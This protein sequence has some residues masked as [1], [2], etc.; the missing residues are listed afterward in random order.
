M[1][2]AKLLLAAL[3]LA[4]ALPQQALAYTESPYTL[5]FNTPIATVDHAFRVAPNWRH[6]V[7]G[8]DNEYVSYY[9]DSTGGVDGT[10]CLRCSKQELQDSEYDWYAVKDIIVTPMVSGEISFAGK[11]IGSYGY[12]EVYTVNE[13]GRLGTRLQ[14]FDRTELSSSTWNTVS[15]TTPLETSQRIGFRISEAAIDD[16]TAAS[17]ERELEKSLQVVSAVPVAE[18]VDYDGNGATGTIYWYQQPYTVTPEGTEPGKVLVQYTVTVKNDGEVNLAVGDENYSVSI[19][20][21]STNTVYGTT[22]ITQDLAVGATSEPFVVEALVPAT[23]WP[24]SYRY[25]NMNV[26]ENMMGSVLTRAQSHYRAYEPKLLFREAGSRNTN[27]LA[28]AINLGMVTEDTSKE[29][30][31]FNDGA[32]PLTIKSITVPEGFTCVVREFPAEGETEGALVEGEFSVPRKTRKAVTVTLPATTPGSYSGDIKIIYL[33]KNLEEATYTLALSGTVL[34]ANTW[35]TTFD[36]ADTGQSVQYPLGSV[37]EGGITS[38]YRYSNGVYDIYLKSYTYSGYQTENNKFITPKL[39]A[40]AG[41]A[42]TFDVARDGTNSTYSMKVYI[43]TDRENW[44]E[45]VAT[46]TPSDM[47]DS[48][49]H[50]ESITFAEAGDYYVGFAIFGMRLDNVVGLEKVD[51]PHDVYIKNVN[52]KEIAQSGNEQTATLTIIPLSEADPSD[53]TVE[54]YVNGEVKANVNTVG[55]YTSAT[56]ETQF[57]AKW[58][59]EVTATT[60]LSTYFKLTFTD[61]TA[62]FQ[63]PVKEITIEHQPEFVFFDKGTYSGPY[64][65][66]ENRKTAIDFGKTNTSG[67]TQQFEIHNWGTAPLT[68]KSITVPAGFTALFPAAEEGAEAQPAG[69]ATVASKERQAVDIVLTA[70]AAGTYEGNL[71]IVYVDA[72]GADATFTLPVKAIMLDPNKWYVT[73]DDGT[74]SGVFPA[75]SIAQSNVSLTNTGS[76]SAPDVCVYSASTSDNM[77]ITP[78]MHIATAGETLAFDAKWLP[79]T[80]NKSILR[81]YYAATREALSDDT[82]RTLLAEYDYSDE[83]KPQLTESFTTYTVA[84]PEAGDFFIGFEMR[85]R[86]YINDLYGLTLAPFSHDLQ[87]AGSLIPANGVQNTLETATISFRN[88]GIKPEAEGTFTL[89][90]YVNGEPQTIEGYKEIPTV[91]KANAPTTSFDIPF[92]SPKVGTFPVYLEFKAG[93]FVLATEPQDVTFAEETLSSEIVVGTP[94]GTSNNIPLNLYYKNSESVALYT[95]AE[96]GLNGGEKIV[97]IA[98]K[99]YMKKSGYSSDFK[100]YYQW[101]DDTELTRPTSSAAFDYSGM[102]RVVDQ[103]AYE[104]PNVGGDGDL[105]EMLV[106]NFP[107]PQ[108]YEAGK[109]LRLFVRSSWSS[110]AGDSM[111][112]IESSQTK[113]NIF[114]HKNEG[115][116]DVFTGTWSAINEQA[117]PVLHIS[118]AVTPISISGNVTDTEGNAAEGA[119]V[120]LVSTDGDNIQ[121]EGTTDATGAYNVNVI[122]SSRT[123]DVIVTKDGKEDYADAVEFPESKTTDFTLYEVANLND[124][125]NGVTAIESALVKINLG[126]KPGFNA[127]ALPVALTSDEVAAIFGEDAKVYE[128]V[129]VDGEI[130]ATA[131]FFTKTDGME[132]GVPY[133]LELAEAPAPFKVKGRAVVADTPSVAHYAVNFTATYAPMAVTD[134]MFFLTADNYI[135]TTAAATHGLSFADNDAAAETLPAFRAYVKQREGRELQNLHFD[136]LTDYTGIEGVAAD[137]DEN[138]EI[139][140]LQGI[141]VKNP[142]RGGVYIVNGK[143]VLVK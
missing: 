100:L 131:H 91:N 33:D 127:I 139:Y 125:T 46:Y 40:Q 113:K 141:R 74:S 62:S 121:Y 106:I 60:T 120:T 11:L 69:A 9:Y 77:F 104:W 7:E 71:E 129:S 128:F 87:I 98:M 73:F 108:V 50:K 103:A 30:E 34:G 79:N 97:K 132:A 55:L 54:Y 101:T 63:T 142:V 18:A 88:F 76:Y 110:D 93:D 136:I 53:Y 102:T 17:A 119:T 114:A 115:T 12:I 14:R 42:L 23:E 85:E 28:S 94:S 67:L 109:S 13:D 35:S 49:W 57:N 143:K 72:T 21:G 64:S 137:F 80:W 3:G 99:G 19:I 66:P 44:G 116:K 37:A 68:V 130:D 126:L 4:A 58:T 61:G 138:A 20:N 39:R 92:R 123:Y 75:G 134:G 2:K 36:S 24:S 38:D 59:P 135:A 70:D 96:L 117:L 83:T 25:I 10:G 15:L 65:K 22:N 1:K 89:T 29:F 27:S 32:A 43:S 84:L 124:E 47:G 86:A 111:F 140:N 31:I 133:L 90:A 95:P 45:P 52:Q 78:K 82:Q 5:D 118:L 16:F 6:I 81:V 26:R 112:V 51:V 107:E 41:D 122:Q 105:V 8:V 48:A 56:R